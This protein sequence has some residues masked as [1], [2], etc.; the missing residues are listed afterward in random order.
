MTLILQIFNKFSVWC[1]LEF[2]VYISKFKVEFVVNLLLVKTL[3]WR[4]KEF[5]HFSKNSCKPFRT[6]C[7]F[8]YFGE[9]SSL[10]TS[11]VGY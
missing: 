1:V 9:H 3:N 11:T 2:A 10:V 4:D 7:A 6:S 8:Q 5:K